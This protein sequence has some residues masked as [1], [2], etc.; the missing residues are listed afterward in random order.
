MRILISGA[1]IAGLAL[2]GFLKEQGIEP[3]LLEKAQAWSRVGYGIALW[4][5]GIR[6][7]E[8]LGL[9][10]KFYATGE[11]IEAWTLRDGQGKILKQADL[12]L[13]DLPPLTAIHRA[14]LHGV[15][16]ENVPQE[17]IRMET[18]L[19]RVQPGA[20]GVQV[21]LS[22]G[23]VEEYDLIVGA[24]GVRSRLRSLAFN[25]WHL[26]NTGTAT[27][28]FWIPDRITPPHGFTEAWMEGGKAFLVAP[29][30]GRHMG[31][32]AVPI[33]ADY[34][35][36]DHWNW[37]QN[38]VQAD[39]W[40]LPAVLDA[41]DDPDTVYHDQNYRVEAEQWYRDRMVLI[42]DAAHAMHP[43]VGMGASL[44]LEDAYVLA[45]E[46][47][48]IGA[49]RIE[50]ALE[51]YSQRRQ[52]RVAT[53][54]KQAELTW[55][56]TFTQQSLFRLMRNFAVQYTPFFEKFF[57]KQAHNVATDLFQKL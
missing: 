46:L 10:E 16:L 43:I 47:A 24:D 8:R 9:A 28:S 19:D 25:H 34:D 52:H 13:E 20:E 1:G 41:V 33:N 35:P 4:G 23:S 12:H 15:L 21:Y 51:R 14:D 27:W 53:F 55:R 39:E 3:V 45:D 17:W 30:S 31:S 22:D 29:V 42:G 6:I 50:Q 38:Q 49:E 56:V 57:L 26:E 2:A 40:L 37:L 32:V 44:A 54:Q 18:T 36:L 11:R 48:Q 7:L 5:N